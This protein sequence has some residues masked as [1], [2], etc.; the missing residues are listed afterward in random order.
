MKNLVKDEAEFQKYLTNGYVVYQ[1][2]YKF[3]PDGR[4]ELTSPDGVTKEGQWVFENNKINMDFDGIKN[5]I[6]CED[7]V[8]PTPEP[9]PT[10]TGG[11]GGGDGSYKNCTDFPFIKFCKNTK[12]AE[13]QK[14]LGGLVADG[15][16]GPK[17]EDALESAGYG[18]DI[19]EDDYNKIMEKC[20]KV[21]P[22]PEKIVDPE[23]VVDPTKET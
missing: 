7:I 18:T 1:G 4:V 23:V 16:F 22:S 12:I 11:G 20:G 3:Y 6:S 2:A 21:E 19:S 10:T 17:T 13:V 14:C 8:L 5:S 9:T 15:K